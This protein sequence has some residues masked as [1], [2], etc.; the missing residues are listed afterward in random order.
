MLLGG[1][2]ITKNSSTM[3]KTWNK[4]SVIEAAL[5]NPA[6]CGEL[7]IHTIATYNNVVKNGIF[8]YPLGYLVLPFLLNNELFNELPRT[9]R[10]N[11]ITWIISH[12]YLIPI[13]VNKTCD[14]K[15]YT[16][17][18]ILFF[19]STNILHMN[20]DGELEICSD[21]KVLNSTLDRGA[22]DD[23]VKKADFI[24]K[25]LGDAGDIVT[26]FSLIGLT[27]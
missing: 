18:A 10:T 12:N 5:Y 17:E 21:K 7:I 19:L 13:I 14:L 22:V 9:K 6:F 20:K 27:I 26:I 11:F 2:P 25:W 16:D 23:L 1:T 15:K 3:M 8:P 24:G 4:R